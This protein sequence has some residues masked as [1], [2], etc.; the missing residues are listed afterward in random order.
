MFLHI[1]EDILVPL[2][3]MIGIVDLSQNPSP[4]NGEFLKTAEEEGF[5]VQ[6]SGKPTS[7]VICAQ[8]VYLSPISAQTLAKRA[9]A[10]F[11]YL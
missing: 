5:V 11:D 7:V 9:Q 1:G 4:I 2:R 6:L 3:D 8:K 10:R